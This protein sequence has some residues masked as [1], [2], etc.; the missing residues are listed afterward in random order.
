[1]IA[2]LW[3]IC[4]DKY[5]ETMKRKRA[6]R[7]K[8]LRM[9]VIVIILIGI[10]AYGY[11]YTNQDSY[12]LAKIGYQVE[13]INDILK[14]DHE[15]IAIA[16]KHDYHKQLPTLLAEKYMIPDHLDR[17]LKYHQEHPDLSMAMVVTMVNVNRDRDYYQQP[18]K[19]D[20]NKQ[21]AMLVNKYYA[22][23]K[24]YTPKDLVSISNQYSYGENAVMKEVYDQYMAMYQAAKQHDLNLIITSSYR[25]Y[26]YQEELWNHYKTQQG[27]TWADSVSARAGHSEHQTG[28]T[29]D[30]ATYGSVFNDFANTD[31]FK[32]MEKHAH[33]YG[34][35]LRYPERKEDITG[36]DYESWHYRYV[37]VEIA[38]K[39]KELNIT[40]DEYYAYYIEYNKNS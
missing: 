12:R 15:K 38:T 25:D 2:P 31:E 4:Y 18:K 10:S 1:M 22:L 5:G 34:F 13:E 20:T 39:I 7:K 8:R 26:E 33:Q 3:I 30:I 27:Q 11:Y 17:Y 32:W 23:D 24:N 9:M 19:T 37:G 6:L 36:Y 14:L 21:T 29:L 16:L 40:F 35:I 28:L